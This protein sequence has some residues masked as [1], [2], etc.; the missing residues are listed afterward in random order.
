MNRKPLDEEIRK[1]VRAL[2]QDIPAGLEERFLEKLDG[3]PDGLFPVKQRPRRVSRGVL[4]AAASLLIVVLL[5]AVLL[6]RPAQAPA[7]VENDVF[8]DYA[9]VEGQ[10]ATTYI[11]NRHDPDITFVWIEKVPVVAMNKKNEKTALIKR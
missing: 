10:P 4:A 9:T 8:I 5:A 11:V 7:V 2:E 1:R 3:K 6:F